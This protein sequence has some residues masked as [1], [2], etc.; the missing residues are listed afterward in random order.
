MTIFFSKQTGPKCGAPLMNIRTEMELVVKGTAFLKTHAASHGLKTRNRKRHEVSRDISNH[1]ITEHGLP[2]VQDLPPD[3]STRIKVRY[4]CP[5][6]FFSRLS[7]RCISSLFLHCSTM[8]R[9]RKIVGTN[10]QRF[11]LGLH[12][13]FLHSLA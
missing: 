2:I 12:F 1:Y 8:S 5:C 13:E 3:I 4:I 11:H 7:V 10:W 6:D 9:S